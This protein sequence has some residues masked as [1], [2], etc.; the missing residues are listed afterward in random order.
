MSLAED[1][2]IALL[3]SG[4]I[5]CAAVN[6]PGEYVAT[7]GDDKVL[8]IWSLEHLKLLS[9]RWVLIQIWWF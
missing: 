1:D 6:G 4:P 7:I 3:K 5:R 2:K 8:K 9:S